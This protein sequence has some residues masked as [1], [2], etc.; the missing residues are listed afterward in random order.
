MLNET[1]A[2]KFLNFFLIFEISSPIEFESTK[3]VIMGLC[4]TVKSVKKFDLNEQ[5]LLLQ[6]IVRRKMIESRGSSFDP[7]MLASRDSGDRPLQVETGGGPGS[8]LVHLRVRIVV[9]N[10]DVL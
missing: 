1:K 4:E 10:C 9:I 5:N 7:L 8:K 3:S 6:G 2:L